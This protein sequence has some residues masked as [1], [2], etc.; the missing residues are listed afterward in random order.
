MC[1]KNTRN[2]TPKEKGRIPLIVLRENDVK[3]SSARNSLCG[4]PH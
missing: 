4:G 1:M 3:K 2:F